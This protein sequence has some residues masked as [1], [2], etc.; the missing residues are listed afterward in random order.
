M[1]S[2]FE[3]LESEKK[4]HIINAALK[5]FAK[6]GYEKASTNNIVKEARISK[7]SLYN[8]F[9][10]KKG[11]YLYLVEVSTEI[12]EQVYALIDPKE[13]DIFLKIEKI[14]FGKIEIQQRYP[15]VFDFLFSMTQDQ[16]ADITALNKDNINKIYSEGL[17]KMYENIDYYLFKDEIDSEKAINILNWTILGYG[18]QAIET[19]SSTAELK[20]EY[21][22][23][24]E[25]YSK[26]LRHAFYK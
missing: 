15:Q 20:E 3:Q 17:Q 12:I 2:A 13:S 22:K 10:T 14:G 11:L 6:N 24:W 25:S 1:Y 5:E 8:Y 9:G 4:S 7:G 21:L 18:N 26:I 23:D 16:S 19:K